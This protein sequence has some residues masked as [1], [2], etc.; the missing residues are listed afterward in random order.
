MEWLRVPTY[1]SS[2][3]PRPVAGLPL[4][5]FPIPYHSLPVIGLWVE[6]G[7]SPAGPPC[8]V[9]TAELEQMCASLD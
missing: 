3:P 7:P 4:A 2:T 9:L 1:I 6:V 8:P 5:Q